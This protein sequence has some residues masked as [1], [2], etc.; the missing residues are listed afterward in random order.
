MTVQVNICE[1][2]TH[3]SQ[4]VDQAAAGED[5]IIARNGRPVA[6]LCP[7]PSGIF[8]SLGPLTPLDDAALDVALGFVR[9]GK[10]LNNPQRC[11]AAVYRHVVR[12]GATR[13]PGLNS[14]PE[15]EDATS[16]LDPEDS[17]LDL[18]AHAWAMLSSGIEPDTGSMNAAR[19][20]ASLQSLIEALVSSVKARRDGRTLPS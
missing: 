10:G 14:F 13:I 11:A 6:R 5:I 18:L 2:R 9:P 3:L 1:A 8:I 17:E 20:L 16:P 12:H 7:L 15:L 19:S 4:L